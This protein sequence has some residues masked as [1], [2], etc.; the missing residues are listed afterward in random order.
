MLMALSLPRAP[1]AVDGRRVESAP[2]RL[3]FRRPGPPIYLLIARAL[4]QLP[5]RRTGVWASATVVLG[6]LL[7][8]LVWVNGYYSVVVK[9]QFREAA[10]Y[11]VAHDAPERPALVLACAWRRDTFSYYLVRL[12]SP[13]RVERLAETAADA[14]AVQALVAERQPADV[15]LLAGHKEPEPALL[16]A[17]AA[18]LTLVDE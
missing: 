18:R 11:L 9:E 3:T 12:G 14:A 17:L 1:A 10:A 8:Q 5:P 7:V 4:T 15:W 2:M 13:R 16:A 6:L